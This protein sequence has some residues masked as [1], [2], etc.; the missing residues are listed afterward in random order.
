MSRALVIGHVVGDDVVD[1]I[2]VLLTED[3]DTGFELLTDV[4]VGRSFK[5]SLELTPFGKDR[6]D[7]AIHSPPPRQ[8][9]RT[10]TLR[11]CCPRE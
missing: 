10:G 2:L 6:L 11:G 4:R 5:L 9:P 8:V 1:R 7:L 3:R